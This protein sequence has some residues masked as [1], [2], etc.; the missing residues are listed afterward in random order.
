MHP[1]SARADNPSTQ[2]SQ[3]ATDAIKQHFNEK[4]PDSRVEVRLNPI[5]QQL[6]FPPCGHPLSVSLPFHSGAR[7][8]AK[9]GCNQPRWSL[10]ITGHVQIF[11][12]V[13][14]TAGPIVKGSRIQA[15]MLQ[16]REQDIT[17]LNGDYFLRQQDVNGRMA[18]I[19]INADSVITP[20]MLTHA[21]A[22]QRG[23]P[24]IIEAG[25][26]GVVIRAEGKAQGT[27]RIGDIIDVINSRSGNTI[28][29]QVT[30]PGRVRVP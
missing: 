4:V 26:K 16:L 29:A 30:A 5:N 11:K 8:T 20:R 28:R 21:N 18:R 9:V 13:I 22:V 1:F 15:N 23:D 17:S 6:D 14:M 2:I 12:P 7:I 3:Q 19:S 25:R 24:V 10:F 27:G